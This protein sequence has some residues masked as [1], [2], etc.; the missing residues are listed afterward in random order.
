MIPYKAKRLQK[1]TP[2]LHH[3][4]DIDAIS[5][6]G[7]DLICKKY[8]I[9]PCELISMRCKAFVEHNT[10]Y[11]CIIASTEEDT[12]II[13]DMTYPECIFR[14]HGNLNSPRNSKL[15]KRI[16]HDLIYR[17]YNPKQIKECLR[18][19]ARPFTLFYNPQKGDVWD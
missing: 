17:G 19:Y 15:I 14:Y 12:Y 8:H 4:K 13:P 5:T 9:E 1:V 18:P 16:I 11:H 2:T 10:L 3:P 7:E 6:I